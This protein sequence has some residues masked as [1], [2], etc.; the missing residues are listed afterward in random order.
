MSKLI[1]KKVCMVGPFAVGKTSLVR[2]F[3]ESI[4]SDTYLTTIGVKISK[5]KMQVND[6]QIQL[7]IWDIEGVDVF[8]EL[9]PSYLRG[10]AGIFLVLD[11]TRPKSVDMAAE[12]TKT[13]WEQLPGVPILG[14][15]NKSD[16]T[17]EWK[18][19]ESDI[20]GLEQLGITIIKSSAKTGY[21]VELAFE[22]MI[23]KMGLGSG[24][25][26]AP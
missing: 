22:M 5:K 26:E 7:M 9:K 10:A 3:V 16:M 23:H 1:T 8:T 25:P 2:R 21:N 13:L 11:G 6:D 19:S 12:L 24:V 15:L 14:L 4:F 17:Y 20:E 18:I